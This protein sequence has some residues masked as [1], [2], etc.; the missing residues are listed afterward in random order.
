MYQKG[1]TGKKDSKH[2]Y[3]CQVGIVKNTIRL[4]DFL[5]GIQ[6]ANQLGDKQ[7]FR[8]IFIVIQQSYILNI[9]Y[10]TIPFSFYS[11]Y[12]CRDCAIVLESMKQLNEA[13]SLYEKGQLYDKAAAIY[14][15]GISLSVSVSVLY[16]IMEV[17]CSNNIPF[18]LSIAK[19]YTAASSLMDKITTPKLHQQYGLAMEEQRKYAEAE[20]AYAFAKDYDNVIRINLEYLGNPEK[21]F[22]Y[23]H[24]LSSISF[25]Q[26]NS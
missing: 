4:G 23:S 12:T 17:S 5:K 1:L 18:P 8:Y 22:N 19:N 7:V 14:L 26:I 24:H 13:A 11:I 6:M 10:L 21:V 20:K 3:A 2:D 9:A 16:M 15:K 25:I